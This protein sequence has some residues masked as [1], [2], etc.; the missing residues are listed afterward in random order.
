MAC[1]GPVN[2]CPLYCKAAAFTIGT[3]LGIKPSENIILSDKSLWIYLS[4]SLELKPLTSI[5]NLR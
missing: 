4:V 5:K 3:K 1:I 2:I